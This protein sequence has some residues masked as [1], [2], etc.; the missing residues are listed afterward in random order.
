MENDR[1]ID[2]A[3]NHELCRTVHNYFLDYIAKGYDRVRARRILMEDFDLSYGEVGLAI[4]LSNEIKE[5]R[6]EVKPGPPP[7]DDDPPPREKGAP[8]PG[9]HKGYDKRQRPQGREWPTRMTTEEAAEFLATT[10]TSIRKWV[11]RGELRRY[12]VDPSTRRKVPVGDYYFLKCELREY[13]KQ[14]GWPQLAAAN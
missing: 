7:A 6:Y 1:K 13:A 14:R 4:F 10:P 9:R 2:I 12:L 8:S 5:G 11:K 3:Y